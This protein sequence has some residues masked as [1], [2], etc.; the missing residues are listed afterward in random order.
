ME[1]SVKRLICSF[2]AAVCICSASVLPKVS[3]FDHWSDACLTTDACLTAS[4]ASAESPID[5]SE[6]AKTAVKV[7]SSYSCTDDSV[8]ISWKKVEGACGYRVY[9]RDSVTKKYVKIKTIKSGD[10]LKYKDSGLEANTEQLYKVKAYTKLDGKTVW[11][12]ASKVKKTVTRPSAAPQFKS[13][14]A[15]ADKTSVSWSCRDCDGYLIS[16]YSDAEDE[17]KRVK[18][19]N[20][21]YSTACTLD[22]ADLTSDPLC[23][24][25]LRIK[26]FSL[27][28]CSK[29]QYTSAGVSAEYYVTEAVIGE[30]SAGINRLSG[31]KT[32]G[33]TNTQQKTLKIEMLN[34][35]DKKTVKSSFTV[36]QRDI[37]VLDNFAKTHFKSGWSAEQKAAYTLNWI[38]KN[39]EYA[40][41][42]KY[43]EI[44][45]LG[46]AEAVFEHK[47]GQC[48]Q[49]N[50]AM[51]EM[52]NYLGYDARLIM[53]W[54][55][56][57]MDNKWQHFWGETTVGGTDLVIETGCYAKDGGW[58]HFCEPYS[59]A[60]GYI[61]NDKVMKK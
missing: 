9:K 18:T 17:W 54:R 4:A 39:I 57:S 15:G 49:Y 11:G 51:V 12:K 35:Q 41:A 43:N 22:T 8:T 60:S 59:A 48:L 27:D 58:M 32:Q 16:A 53:G 20:T 47:L 29:A 56:T 33:V 6:F 34:V 21:P 37:Q 28:G 46:Y 14:K 45:A 25:K 7:K 3:P 5:T 23:P 31:D 42:D 2:F 10:T 38:N 24:I 13:V 30:L 52:M 19:V 61:K 26:A 55:G 44:A 50:G 40:Y 1:S 36:S